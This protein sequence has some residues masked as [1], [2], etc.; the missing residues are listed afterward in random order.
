MTE[1]RSPDVTHAS[2]QAVTASTPS[3]GA[4]G[5]VPDGFVPLKLTRNPFIQ[6]NGPL[7]GRWQDQVFTLGLRVEARQA[8][9][10]A[11]ATVAC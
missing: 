6:A 9:R 1:S 3:A 11:C 4:D 7:Y 2:S 5:R 10:A 8:T